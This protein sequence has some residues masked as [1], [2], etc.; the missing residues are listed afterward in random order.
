MTLQLKPII[1]F[2]VCCFTQWLHAQTTQ[3]ISYTTKE[4][5]SSN[6]VYR[7]AIDHRGFLWIATEN[8]L[9]RFDG[10]KFETYTT[11]RGLTD[12]EIIDLVIDSS[13]TIWAIP[14]R[15]SPCYYNPQK[16]RF[17][18]ESTDPELNKID[19]AN[20]HK[21]HV[22][23]YGGIAFSNNQKNLF[24]YKNGKTQV[25]KNFMPVKT[26]VI[27]KIAEYQPGRYIFFC[28]D[29]IRYFSHGKIIRNI[30]FGKKLIAAEYLNKK[31]YMVQEK[32]VI[33]LGIDDNGALSVSHEKKYPFEI[34]IFCNTGKGFAITSLSGN[35]Y[36]V[37][38]ASLDIKENVYTKVQVRNVLEDKESN[39]WLSTMENG[40]IKIQQKRISSFTGVPEMT[41]NFNTLIK[42]KNIIAG[43]NN[44][45]IYVYD[46]LY[47]TRR[48][49]L[50]DD[51]NI[52]AWVR[53]IV[54]TS[55][56]IFVATQTGSFLFDDECKNIR[57][58]FTGAGNRSSKT[59]VL[60]NDSV[61]GLGSHSQAWK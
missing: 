46:G 35:T 59:A 39:T 4:G 17:E 22:L 52:D 57:Q 10:R 32:S 54:E 42:T 11:A 21:I 49:P 25:F 44:G 53:K 30:P 60:L 51:R 58:K 2:A 16:D 34:R 9:A 40:L 1:F 5:L 43:T 28:E 26:G 8:G 3:T 15:R 18:N 13:G 48:I 6:S 31:I 14:F 47:K 29:T 56:G 24:V 33:T 55:K 19:L 23:Q 61:L 20:T 41:Q 12:N 37:D 50:T 38:T 27:Q 36:L 7:T 45:E